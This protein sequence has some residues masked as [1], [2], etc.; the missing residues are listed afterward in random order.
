M[1]KPIRN[2]RHHQRRMKPPAKKAVSPDEQERKARHR[3]AAV[4]IIIAILAAIPFSLGKYFEFNSPGFFDSG[5]YVYSAEHILQGAKIGVDEKPSAQLGTLLVNLLGVRLFGFSDTGP[6]IIQMVLQAAALIIMFIAMRKLFSSIL[7]A[8]VGV[9]IASVYLSAPVIAKYGNVKEQYMIACMVMGVSCFVLYQLGGK[10]W[11]AVLAGGFAIWAPLFKPTGVSAFGAMGLFVVLQPLLKN[12]SWKQAG[13]D[14]LLLMAGVVAAIAPLYI[15]I[16]AWNVQITLPYSF[17]WR[18]LGKMLPSAASDTQAK[19]ATDYIGGSRKLVPFS[20]QLPI[21]LRY[22]SVL[23]LPIALAVGAIIARVIRMIWQHVSAKKTSVKSYDRFVLL[24]AVWWIL[25]MA[26]VWISPH[27]Y[28]QYYLPLNASAAMLGGYLIA[29]YCD[30]IKFAANKTKWVVAGTIGIILMIVLSWHIFFGLGKSPY[31]GR[32]Y[33]EKSRGYLQKFGE[34]PLNPEHPW[35]MVSEHIRTHS[36]PTDKIY[37]WGW[38]PGIY[39]KAQRLSSAAR[40]FTS[41]MHIR[42]PDELAKMVAGLLAEF[43]KEPPKFFVDTHNA[44]FPYDGR[45]PLELWP[46]LQQQ[47]VKKANIKAANSDEAYAEWLTKNVDSDEAGR[48]R[49]MKPFR[50][51]VMKNYKIAQFFGQVV[52]FELKSPP[53]GK[54]SQ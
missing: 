13:F 34:I 5:A 31:S 41:T 51:Y 12:R 21:V 17:L 26:F 22:Y 25:D 3:R 27:S 7:P 42:P 1:G 37:V 36:Q 28:E 44:H 35:L 32:R 43:E 9:I 23:I 14:I 15:W 11:L 40:A 6:K 50:E 4:L 39:V 29:I 49:A 19:P 45:P 30:K 20:K 38:V 2:I 18:E 16:L 33:D 48:F 24:L 52:L 46:F 47:I 54:E 10:W 8:A 53:A